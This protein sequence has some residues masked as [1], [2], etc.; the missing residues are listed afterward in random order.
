MEIAMLVF[1]S[2]FGDAFAKSPQVGESF[3][4]FSKD[5]YQSFTCL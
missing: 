5:N 1:M 2:Y 4:S 3:V